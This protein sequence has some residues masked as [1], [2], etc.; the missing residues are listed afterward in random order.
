MGLVETKKKQSGNRKSDEI[1]T[2]QQKTDICQIYICKIKCRFETQ[3]TQFKI[4]S[5]NQT[6]PDST[7]HVILGIIIMIGKPPLFQLVTLFG[8]LN[9][10]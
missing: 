9:V 2:K 10:D 6:K 4:Q 7:I 5:Q 3:S 8:N 1:W